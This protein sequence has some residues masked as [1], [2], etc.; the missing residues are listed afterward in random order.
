MSLVQPIQD[1]ID[2]LVH[3]SVRQDPLTATRH[4]A[5]IAPRLLGSLMILAALPVYLVVRGVPSAIEIAVFAWLVVPIATAYYLSWTGRYEAAHIL[6]S[7]ALAGL[8]FIVAFQTGGISS[9]AMPWLVVVPLEA[10]LSASRRV[11]AMSSAFA[12]A[13][14]GALLAAQ[15]LGM[16]PSSTLTTHAWL[17]ALGIVSAAVYA[18]ALAL[19]TESLSRKSLRL[20]VAEEDRYRLLARN[21]T[22]VITRHGR[23]GA[24]LFV[25]PAAQALFHD[26]IEEL[27]GHG[28]FER[29][30]VADRPAYLS[31]LA[32]AAQGEQQSVEFRVKRALGDGKTG[33]EFVWVEMRCRPLGQAGAAAEREVVAVMRDISDRK[34]QEQA[35][36]D[37]R[38]ESECANAAK[39][40]FLATMSH[41]LRTPL[42]AIIGFSEMLGNEEQMRLDAT[43]RREY[44]RLINDSGTHL[45]AVVNGILDMSKMETGD[46]EITPE[47]F[48][49]L[50]VIGNC[51]DILALRAR[52]AGLDLVMRNGEDIPELV[53]DKRAFK[54][55]MLNLLSNAIKFTDRGGH[56]IIASRCDGDRL[57]VSVE[58]NGVGI[59]AADLPRIGNPFFQARSTYDRRHDGTGLGLSIVKGLVSLHGGDMQVRSEL[60]KGTVISIHL[61]LDCETKVAHRRKVGTMTPLAM[62]RKQNDIQVRKSA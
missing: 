7:F 28:L 2:S 37:A 46:F 43:K 45:L 30:H 3:P 13:A 59:S 58:D 4:R 34:A 15:Q 18:T 27:K 39:T 6:S 60:G 53:A 11:V 44:A 61:P 48:A 40:R 21:M 29:V 14:A 62:P 36:D 1:H 56:I 57:V 26:R 50:K 31:A 23:N 38:A 25:S 49:P 20:L 35:L 16:T 41:E 19:V 55:I 24:V 42:N 22:D 5:F 51:C 32:D 47:P 54:Q 33:V 9:F 10:S 17:A 8:V 52:E 12:L